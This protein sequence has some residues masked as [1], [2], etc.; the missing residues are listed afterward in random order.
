MK[1]LILKVLGV[2]TPEEKR[3]ELFQRMFDVKKQ[4]GTWE[5]YNRR[6]REGRR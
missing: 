1:R 3:A 2:K 5:S 4:D 6:V